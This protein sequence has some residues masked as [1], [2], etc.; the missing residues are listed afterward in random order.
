MRNR[1][2]TGFS[3]TAYARDMMRLCT[4][5]EKEDYEFPFICTDCGWPF[6]YQENI[7]CCPYCKSKNIQQIDKWMVSDAQ[8]ESN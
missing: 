8:E 4:P 3:L 7:T 5:E 2:T 1:H 6:P